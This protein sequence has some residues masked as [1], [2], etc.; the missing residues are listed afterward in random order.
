MLL[1]G[2]RRGV[3]DARPFH[4]KTVTKG[5]LPMTAYPTSRKKRAFIL[6]PRRQ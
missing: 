3:L 4:N 6:I 1:Y 5:L 2:M